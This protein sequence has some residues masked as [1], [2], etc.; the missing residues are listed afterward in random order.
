MRHSVSHS[1]SPAQARSVLE[2]AFGAYQSRFAKYEPKIDWR[3][4][5]LAEV[6]FAI[7]GKALRG[8]VELTPG[9]IVIELEVPL[10]FRMFTRQATEIIEREIRKWVAK[11]EAGELETVD[12]P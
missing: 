9:A 4:D 7:K 2:H 10:V 5:S 1:L 12:A 6:S 3:S 11:A 8:Q